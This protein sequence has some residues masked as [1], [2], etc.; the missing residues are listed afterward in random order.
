MAEYY[1]VRNSEFN[2]AYVRREYLRFEAA[3]DAAAEAEAERRFDEA[4]DGGGD[5][6][7]GAIVVDECVGLDDGDSETGWVRADQLDDGQRA[8]LGDNGESQER[9]T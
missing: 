6:F 2:K 3:D 8:D 5:P 4:D 9:T 1:L 7:E